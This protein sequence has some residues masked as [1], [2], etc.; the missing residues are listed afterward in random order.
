MVQGYYDLQ[1]P[2][3]KIKRLHYKANIATGFQLLKLEDLNCEKSTVKPMVSEI[4]DDFSTTGL[5]VKVK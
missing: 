4:Q 1:D 2:D 3:C 5:Q